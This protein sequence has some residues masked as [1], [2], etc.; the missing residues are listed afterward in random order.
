MSLITRLL[1]SPPGL[2]LGRIIHA[3]TLRHQT[4][5]QSLATSLFRNVRQISAFEGPLSDLSGGRQLR[6]LVAGCSLGCEAYTLAG[7][8]AARFPALAVSIDAFDIDPGA[9]EHARGAIYGREH[10]P[11]GVFHGPF[12][13]VAEA[14]V[15]SSGEQWRIKENV[16][17]TVRFDVGDAL[18]KNSMNSGQYDVVLAQNFM[19]HMDDIRAGLALNAMADCVRP[20]GAMLLG[21]MTLDMREKAT[22]AV[23]LV[24][25]DWNIEAI[26]NEDI[27]RRNA[28]PFA[29]WSLE[30]LD[31]ARPDW[32]ARY[33]T[34][35]RKV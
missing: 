34:I 20:G 33:A 25:I 15:E 26:H 29:Y 8:L 13:D 4:R 5:S 2:P 9:V 17:R 24:P 23:G 28:W 3:W 27:V 31:L 1:S 21:G 10:M 18:V 30:P 7:Y 32:K 14:L 11:E 19:V 6:V 16:A 12:A 35:F 22:A